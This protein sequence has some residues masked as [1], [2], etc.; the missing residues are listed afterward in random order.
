MER[1]RGLLDSFP[2]LVLEEGGL[3]AVA[4]GKDDDGRSTADRSRGDD[5]GE[6]DGSSA[7]AKTSV[8][9]DVT[10]D[11]ATQNPKGVSLHEGNETLFESIEMPHIDG[12]SPHV[13]D[14]RCAHGPSRRERFLALSIVRLSI[15]LHSS[16]RESKKQLPF[17]ANPECLPFV[18]LPEL[19]CL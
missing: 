18:F 4:E 1:R 10:S 3:T 7:D 5:L 8:E 14:E 9:G 2:V 17:A 6:A 19:N 15:V 16:C 11:A 13:P 12:D